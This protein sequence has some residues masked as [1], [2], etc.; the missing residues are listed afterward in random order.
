WNSHH[1]KI[2]GRNDVAR[3]ERSFF[4]P[5]SALPFKFES[6]AR[7]KRFRKVLGH[8]RELHTGQALNSLDKV[9]EKPSLSRGV[10]ILRTGQRQ[11][12]GQHLSRIKSQLGA[13]F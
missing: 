5:G 6:N 12:H 11:I 3:R 7:W 2:V 1:A 13:R 8:P 4:C 9:R 10:S